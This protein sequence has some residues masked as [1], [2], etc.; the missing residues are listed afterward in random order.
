MV[1]AIQTCCA[2]RKPDVPRHL[3]LFSQAQLQVGYAVLTGDVGS[4]VPVGTVLFSSTNS[5]GVLV[6]EAGVAAVEPISSGRIFVDQQGDSR[7]A[8]N[9]WVQLERVSGDE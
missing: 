8:L 3:R 9:Y 5:Q 6:W 2:H 1:L 4:N 7:T